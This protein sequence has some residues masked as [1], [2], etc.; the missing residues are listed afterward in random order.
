MN[1]NEF[2]LQREVQELK[3]EVRRLRRLIEGAFAVVGVATVAMFPQILVYVLSIAGLCLFAFL[4]SP[5]RRMIFSS[6]LHKRGED[7][8]S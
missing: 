7:K 2:R 6:I 1:D 5:V 3:T 4:V 8:N